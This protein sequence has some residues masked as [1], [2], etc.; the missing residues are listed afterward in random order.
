MLLQNN[1]LLVFISLFK[2]KKRQPNH[3]LCQNE[4]F[5]KS[6]EH[7]VL[8]WSST[9]TAEKEVERSAHESAP[10]PES[11]SECIASYG[12]NAEKYFY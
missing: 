12:E 5:H 9:D 3:R 1:Y 10:A 4:R 2:A 11:H 8:V 7:G 6:S